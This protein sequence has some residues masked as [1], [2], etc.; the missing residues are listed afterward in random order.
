M[1]GLVGRYVPLLGVFFAALGTTASSFGGE[2]HTQLPMWYLQMQA[3]SVVPALTQ[4]LSLSLCQHDV[5]VCS[6]TDDISEP[7][8]AYT[9]MLRGGSVHQSASSAHLCFLV[10]LCALRIGMSVTPTCRTAAGAAFEDGK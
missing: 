9:H 7:A 8:G 2:K 5:E 1:P 6:G 4:L 3:Q 10:R